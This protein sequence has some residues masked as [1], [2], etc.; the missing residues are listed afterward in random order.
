MGSKL[1]PPDGGRHPFFHK[2]QKKKEAKKKT[3][4]AAGHILKK[5]LS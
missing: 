1:N 3:P 4:T 5:D 2:A